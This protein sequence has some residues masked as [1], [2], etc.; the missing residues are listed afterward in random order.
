M[1]VCDHMNK[2]SGFHIAGLCDHH[3]KKRILAHIPVVCSQDI[4]RSL[5]Q[6]RIK[7]QLVFSGFLGYIESHGIGTWVKIHL[8]EIL[9]YINIGHDPSAVRI[10]LKIKKN[11]VY[12]IHH[13]LFILMLHT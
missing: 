9:M 5:V 3:E 1:A 11:S 4:L 8:V 7:D 10:V 2:L 6:H 13:S 12:L